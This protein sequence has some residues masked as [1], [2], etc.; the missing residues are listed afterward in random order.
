[1]NS[2]HFINH[3]DGH[4]AG[5]TYSVWMQPNLFGKWVV[6]RVHGGRSR[7]AVMIVTVVEN[8]EAGERLIRQICRMRA[9]HG[10][11]AQASHNLST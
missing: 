5:R 2:Y 6:V 10:Y 4:R 9:L 11:D 3:S 8:R 7:A 1:M